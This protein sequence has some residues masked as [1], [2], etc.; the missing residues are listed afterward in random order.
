MRAAVRLFR[1]NRIILVYC[2]IL[3]GII[4]IKEVVS[5]EI[6]L[7]EDKNYIEVWLTKTEQEKYD[8]NYLTKILLK[9]KKTEYKVIFFLSG[10]E[11][12][13][14]CTENLLLRNLNF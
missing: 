5:L 6:N 7:K 9:G 10:S 4:K 14:N 3:R 11:N 1:R 13:L 8:R 12:L 2:T